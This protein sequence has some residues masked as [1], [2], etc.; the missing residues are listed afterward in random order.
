MSNFKSPGQRKFLFAMDKDKQK[1]INPIQNKSQANSIS[2]THPPQIIKPP[3][4]FNAGLSKPVQPYKFPSMGSSI[5]P[6]AVP[7]LPTLSKVPKFGRVK[8]FF[9]K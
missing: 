6:T 3:T 8:K 9:K 2:T 4:T 7:S 1:G 5:T